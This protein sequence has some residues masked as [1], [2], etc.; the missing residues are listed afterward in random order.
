MEL[1]MKQTVS[2]LELGAHIGTGKEANGYNLGLFSHQPGGKDRGLVLGYDSI[3]LPS[4]IS[5]SLIDFPAF[6][7][8]SASISLPGVVIFRV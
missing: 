7:G 1:F 4:L 2:P 8:L 3:L 5:K 6:C